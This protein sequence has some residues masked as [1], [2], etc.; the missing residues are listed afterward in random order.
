MTAPSR[1][2]FEITLAALIVTTQIASTPAQT[3]SDASKAVQAQLDAARK[4]RQAS[5][6]QIALKTAAIDAAIT[7]NV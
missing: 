5:Q 2:L 3:P 6:K 7:V 1:R 4:Q